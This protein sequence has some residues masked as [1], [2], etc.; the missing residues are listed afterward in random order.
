LQGLPADL[1]V[2]ITKQSCR[3]PLLRGHYGDQRF[4][5]GQNFIP[6]AWRQSNI[7]GQLPFL[8]LVK[9]NVH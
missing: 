6:G 3:A 2:I 8:N 1:T 5:G 7:L 9:G 4:I